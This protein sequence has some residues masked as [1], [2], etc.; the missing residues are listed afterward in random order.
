[1]ASVH[2]RKRKKKKGYTYQLIVDYSNNHSDREYIS[3][4]NSE[5]AKA[6]K[7][8]LESQFRQGS[9][10]R[11]CKYTFGEVLDRWI[12]S[13][14]SNTC[15]DDTD[16]GYNLINKKYLK[17]LLGH[18]PIQNIS[19]ETLNDYFAYIRTDEDGPHLSYQTARNH[20]TNISGA[21]TYAVKNKWI[22]ENIC[23]YSEIPKTEEEKAGD[24]IEDISNIKDIDDLYV[25]KKM[26]L[27]PEQAIT[28]LNIF[29]DTCLLLPVA[30]AMFLDLRR[31]EICAIKNQK[32]NK[33]KKILLINASITRGTTG[34]KFKKKNKSKTSRRPYYIPNVLMKIININE[35]RKEENKLLLG[36]AYIESDFLCT[37]DNGKPMK[38]DYL[39]RNF[40]KYLKEYISSKKEKDK[41]YEFPKIT[42]HDLRHFNISCL[43]ENGMNLVDVRD[44]AG[45]SDIRTTM[46]YTHTYSNNKQQ[47]ADKVDEIFSPLLK[48]GNF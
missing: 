2:M 22:K 17:P 26:A 7:S 43:L 42:L 14:V 27:T 36:D 16:Y 25:Q 28:I 4:D 10:V 12:K 32:I 8:E 48:S 38:P 34:L 18:I 11:T 9:Y 13:H 5:D 35:K 31:S 46:L 3:F 6:M 15:D 23:K 21:L 39:S 1:M 19:V 20:K 40:T 45:H 37:L 44:M 41:D 29:K 47:L 33:E 24:Y 30:L